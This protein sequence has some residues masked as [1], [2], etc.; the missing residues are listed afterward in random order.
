MGTCI[1]WLAYVSAM[2]VLSCAQLNSPPATPA[3][4]ASTTEIESGGEVGLSVSSSDPDGDP[5]T[6]SWSATEGSFNSTAG[7]AV[8]WTAPIV[9][10][11][12]QFTVSV[13][14]TDVHGAGASSSV[15]ITVTDTGGGGGFEP[16]IADYIQLY[17][18]GDC[19]ALSGTAAYVIGATEYP[20]RGYVST[21]DVSDPYGMVLLDTMK[22]NDVCTAVDEVY[23]HVYFTCRDS[24]LYVSAWGGLGHL[25]TPGEASDVLVKSDEQIYVADGSKGVHAYEIGVIP[26]PREIGSCETPGFATGL[27]MIGSNLLVADGGAGLRV[28]EA[29][30]PANLSEIGS[31]DTPG[32]AYGVACKGAYAYVADGDAG[33]EVVDMSDPAEPRFLA[34]Y[35]TPGTAY[36]VEVYGD[37]LFVA[38]GMEGLKVLDV[39]DPTGPTLVWTLYPPAFARDVTVSGAFAFVAG[40]YDVSYP[41]LISIKIAE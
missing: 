17:G 19:V 11:D 39:T 30:D 7:T 12:Q 20:E 24:G 16:S 6:Y 37:R 10:T 5:V 40:T 14:A 35:D 34:N 27:G 22:F 25:D 9:S 21:V 28:I 13:V 18:G 1:R 29:S 31:L 2:C 15:N 4:T 41:G 38:D 23:G 36:A 32:Y 8:V 26:N 33:V 3:T